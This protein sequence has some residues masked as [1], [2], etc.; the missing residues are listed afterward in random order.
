[1]LV[2]RPTVG[3]QILSS[4]RE[5]H[6]GPT[7]TRAVAS[8]PPSGRGIRAPTRRKPP[9]APAEVAVAFPAAQT[10]PE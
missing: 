4:G 7:V 2:S 5:A 10:V 9:A 8:L 1:M 6:P 3:T